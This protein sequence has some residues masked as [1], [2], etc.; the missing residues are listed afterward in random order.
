MSA[1]V[2]LCV[3]DSVR[4]VGA[5]ARELQCLSVSVDVELDRCSGVRSQEEESAA[6]V[7]GP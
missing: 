4:G 2:C 6:D 1:C 7:G 5:C 3:F